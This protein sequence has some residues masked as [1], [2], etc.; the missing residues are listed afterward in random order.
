MFAIGLRKLQVA[1]SASIVLSAVVSGV[2][3]TSSS[4]LSNSLTHC[5][6][7]RV[8]PSSQTNQAPHDEF[9][10]YLK[11]P[12]RKSDLKFLVSEFEKGKNVWPWV[13]VHT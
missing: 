1:A 9:D 12:I 6:A 8:P 7:P 4:T 10:I 3:E 11:T 5:E 2:Y 13:Y